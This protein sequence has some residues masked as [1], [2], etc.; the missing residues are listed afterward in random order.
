MS[1]PASPGWLLELQRQF[2]D[3]LRTPLDRSTGSLC[4]ETAA[5]EAKLVGA[6]LPT[7]SLGSTERLAVYHRQYW[8]RLL[9]VMQGLY[10]LTARLAG[11]W[12]FNEFAA[13]HLAGRPPHGFD[14][15][16]VGEGF[17]E[18]LAEQ[19]LGR[20]EVVTASGRQL[21]TAAL[22]EAAHIDAGFHRVT[23]APHLEPLRPG[24]N[25]V[26]RF[27][28]SCLA[29][30]PSVA[31]LREHWSLC[32]R[33]AGFIEGA[34]NEPVLL[35]E[36]LPGPR[37]WLLARHDRQ[38]GLVALEP[39]EAELLGLLQAHPLER[40]LALLEAGASEAERGRLPERAQAWLGRSVRL[41]AWAGFVST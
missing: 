7:P 1:W 22:L 18:G 17:D 39:L 5:Y 15:D 14:I 13:H 9:T 8:F 34:S 6:V 33:R 24:P 35:G 16:A 20:D 25:D 12:C 26:A 3:L 11:Y 36:R 37:H 21:E 32:E 28:S 10:P 2:G 19:L 41:G 40:A 30:S 38:L 29:L 23:R 27:S 31:L 4:A